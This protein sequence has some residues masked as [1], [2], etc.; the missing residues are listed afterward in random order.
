MTEVVHIDVEPVT[1][2]AFAPF[3]RLVGPRDDAPAFNNPGS[4]HG[5]STTRADATEAMYI[6]L[7]MGRWCSRSLLNLTSPSP[8]SPTGPRW[9]WFG[10]R[11]T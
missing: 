11:P 7:T 5:G 6:W 10:A 2:E 4:A 8:S 9:S 1:D 3:G